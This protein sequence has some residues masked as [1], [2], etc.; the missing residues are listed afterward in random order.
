MS[1]V[2]AYLATGIA[3]AVGGQAVMAAIRGLRIKPQLTAL[4]RDFH[5]A[6]AAQGRDLRAA[7]GEQGD[8][9]DAKIEAQGRDLRAAIEAGAMPADASRT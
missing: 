9:L 3:S 6:I 7:I 2:V 1:N 8:R 4:S 5:T